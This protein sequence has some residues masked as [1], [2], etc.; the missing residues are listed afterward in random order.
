MLSSDIHYDNRRVLLT[1][2]AISYVRNSVKQSSYVNYNGKYFV[3]L[4]SQS[5]IL[6]DELEIQKEWSPLTVVSYCT[7][8]YV[9]CTVLRF[10]DN[11]DL[12]YSKHVVMY[13]NSIWISQCRNAEP[14]SLFGTAWPHYPICLG[15]KK[16]V[17]ATYVLQNIYFNYCVKKRK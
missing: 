8:A 3:V 16:S 12:L 6:I 17:T 14:L 13:N 9:R 15:H 4:V 10:V 2:G 5:I 7:P 11:L 1:D